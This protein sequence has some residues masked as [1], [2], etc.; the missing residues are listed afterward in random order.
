MQIGSSFINCTF[1]SNR[2]SAI[3]GRFAF[4]GAV[5]SQTQAGFFANFTGCMFTNNS[6][7]SSGANIVNIAAGALAAGS[8]I[9]TDCQFTGNFLESN[10]IGSAYG[11]AVA[12]IDSLAATGCVFTSNRIVAFL[13]ISVGTLGGGA[14]AEYLPDGILLSLSLEQCT[15]TGNYALGAGQQTVLGGAVAASFADIANCTFTVNAVVSGGRAGGGDLA[16]TAATVSGSHFTNGTAFGVDGDLF[17]GTGGSV[18]IFPLAIMSASRAASLP[19]NVSVLAGST[20][21]GA[22]AI[23]GGTLSV[24]TNAVIS[25]QYCS[26]S[27]SM[28]LRAFAL[29]SMQPFLSQNYVQL[30]QAGGAGAA[31]TL[32]SLSDPQASPT[33]GGCQQTLQY[34]GAMLLGAGVRCTLTGTSVQICNAD[35]GGAIYSAGELS[36]V[37]LPPL[38][39]TALSQNAAYRDGGAIFVTANGTLSVENDVIVLGNAAAGGGAGIYWNS[40]SLQGGAVHIAN[41]TTF[42]DNDSLYGNNYAV[43][44]QRLFAA[45]ALEAQS[46]GGLK[47]PYL[48]EARDVYQS[49][50]VAV[51]AGCVVSSFVQLIDGLDQVV[52]LDVI[53]SVAI[54]AVNHSASDAFCVS[55]VTL[56][57]LTQGRASLVTNVNGAPGST[58]SFRYSANTGGAVSLQSSFSP[59]SSS[60]SSQDG[61]GGTSFATPVVSFTLTNCSVGSQ[62][63]SA[64]VACSTCAACSFGSYNLNGD[65]TCRS[66][67]AATN[68][69][70]PSLRC[71]AQFVF[72][73]AGYWALYSNSSGTVASFVCDSNV[74][75]LQQPLC[76]ADLSIDACVAAVPNN[77]APVTCY[78]GSSTEYVATYCEPQNKCASNR[79]GFMCGRCAS[80]NYSEWNGNCVGTFPVSD[81]CMCCLTSLCAPR[82]VYRYTLKMSYLRHLSMSFCC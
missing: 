78:A 20:W 39:F 2:V 55:G 67:F 38:Y 10:T 63:T 72:A 58:L 21:N 26:I 79:A 17:V 42:A 1:E 70:V 36:L 81:I 82:F 6:V 77:T 56:T 18:A 64:S 9:L 30:Q 62:L 59:S 47:G 76:P 74:C 5:F 28:A 27:S 25:V 44:P 53:G 24:L 12:V 19:F 34:G 69:E 23:S 61:N 3:P 40:A 33:V 31:S 49:V 60:P 35:Y 66:C 45:I 32:L 57:T 7:K 71:Q 8:A 73:A 4:G 43:P 15:F 48:L 65:N 22:T 41:R 75:E 50:S 29:Q 14:V 52:V 68:A 51:P 11:G 37:S 46:C 54:T 13:S 80:E 16:M